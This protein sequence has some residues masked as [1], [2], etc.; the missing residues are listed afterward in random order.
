MTQHLQ[1]LL[2]EETIQ[3]I[4]Q[5]TKP[6]NSADDALHKRSALINEAVKFYIAQKQRDS[7]K[8]QLQEGA[9]RWAERDLGLADEWFDIEEE[10][11]QKP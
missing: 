11:W 7:L 6:D 2:P 4:D 5:L 3:L 9:I 8:Q 1:I 10:V